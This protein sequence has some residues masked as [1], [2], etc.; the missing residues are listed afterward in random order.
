M[1]KVL[2]TGA[3]GFIGSNLVH[4]LINNDYEVYGIDNLLTGRASNLKDVVDTIHFIKGDIRN[5]DL[6]ENLCSEV[7]YVFHQAALPSVP[8]SVDDPLATNDHNIN[9][10]LSVFVAARNTNIDRL[11]YA[12]SSSA[13]GNSPEIPKDESMCP[14]PLSPYAV[15]KH[16]TELYGRVFNEV[17]NLETVGLRYFNVFG[18]RQDPSSDYAAAIPKF[19][20]T[21]LNDDSPVIYGDGEQTRDFTYIENV[22]HANIK[23][24]SAPSEDVAGEIFN[25]GCG[26]RTTVNKLVSEIKEIIGADI[27]P[28]HGEPR[29]G[30]V[31]H[32]Q[33]DISKAREAF[34]YQPKVS[35]TKGLRRTVDWI[36]SR[37]D[38]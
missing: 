38:E 16:A 21:Y 8:R 19:I 28:V 20:L 10:T 31:R 33:A 36:R 34:G 6:V 24:A 32:S 17:Y 15:S 3:A 1:T 13:Y 9:G 22:I 4:Y 25:I 11:V 2:V 35:L 27:D 23:A 37:Q 18:P 14:D 5:Y 7:D 12:A 29:P 30:D 26:Q